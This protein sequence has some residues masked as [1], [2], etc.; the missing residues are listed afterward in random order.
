MK[1][2]SY[3]LNIMRNTEL[4]KEELNDIEDKIEEITNAYIVGITHTYSYNLETDQYEKG[5]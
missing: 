2:H 3:T 1:E 5:K 4:T